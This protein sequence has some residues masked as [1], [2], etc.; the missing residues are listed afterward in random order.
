LELAKFEKELKAQNLTMAKHCERIGLTLDDV[1]RS[2]AWKV[3]W[4]R[5][6][7]QYFTPQSLEKYFERYRRDYDGSQ[8]HVA[9]ILLKVGAD[10]DEAAVS[11]AKERATKLR[12]EITAGKATFADAAKQNSNAP[13]A[14]IGGDIGWIE[15][16]RPMPD[17]FSRAA[18]ALKKGDVSEPIVSPFGVHLITVLEEKP[19]T[20][21]WSDVQAEL[22][23]AITLYLFRWIADKERQGATIQYTEGR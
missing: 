20:K 23:P 6:C 13:S 8:L 10:A 18:F 1:R 16:H 17:D 2:L 5:Y 4:K 7:E 3:S 15:R 22:R 19:G 14:G 11:A 21:T 9:Q 12:Q